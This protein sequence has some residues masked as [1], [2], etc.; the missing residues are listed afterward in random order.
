MRMA[1]PRLTMPARMTPEPAPRPP[2]AKSPSTVKGFAMVRTVPSLMSEV[3]APTTSVPRP[4]GP[5]VI[6]PEATTLSA[7]SMSVPAAKVSPVVKVLCPL[8]ARTPAPDF[9]RLSIEAFWVIGA[10]MI[11]PVAARPALTVMTG[12]FEPKS[13][14]VPEMTGTLT[15]DWFVAVMAAVWLRV[16]EAAATVGLA[17]APSLSKVRPLRVLVPTKVRLPPPRRVT[18]AVAAIWPALVT[19]VTALLVPDASPVMTRSPGTA[20]MPAGAVRLSVPALT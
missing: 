5:L 20:M 8:R 3:P 2:K 13:R 19:I 10:L 18:F 7:P 11:S 4:T 16:S 17:M 1:E 15:G 12:L 14:A 6:A 9:V